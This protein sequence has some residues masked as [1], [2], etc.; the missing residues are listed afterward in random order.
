MVRTIF[1]LPATT[2]R[3]SSAWDPLLGASDSSLWGLGGSEAP[4]PE[5][6][7]E[8][9]SRHACFKGDYTSCLS[10]HPGIAS[11]D[12]S[13]E[14][15]MKRVDVRLFTGA[16]GVL[17]TSSIP[18]DILAAAHVVLKKCTLKPKMNRVW[19]PVHQMSTGCDRGGQKS[20]QGARP[21]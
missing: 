1:L 9:L 5:G 11:F 8:E 13:Q 3:L 14:T 21:C 2:V 7:A 18:A 15:Q 19:S 17:F 10:V 12:G 16:V 4:L 20:E 6:A